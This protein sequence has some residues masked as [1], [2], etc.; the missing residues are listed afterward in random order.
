[1]ENNKKIEKNGVKLSFLAIDQAVIS[2]IQD[3][4]EKVQQG[5]DIVMWGSNNQYPEY[6]WN[7]YTDTTT[8]R[9]IVNGIADYV[10]GDGVHSNIAM[11][12]DEEAEDMVRNLAM[13]YALY[14]GYAIDCERSKA[15]KVVKTMPLDLKCIRSSEHNDFLYYSKKW[16]KGYRNDYVPYSVFNPQGLERSSIYLYKNSSKTVYPLSFL[17][18]DAALAAESERMIAEFHLNQIDNGFSSDFIINMNNGTPT[19]EEQEEIEDNF[20][21]KFCGH[22]NAGR[23]VI[24][25]NADKDHAVTIENIKSEDYG[26]KYQSLKEHCTKKL[27]QAYRALPILFGTPSEQS[28]FA[29]QNY[30]DAFKLFNR[31]MIEPIQKKIAN[32]FNLIYGV[33]QSLVFTPFSLNNNAKV[34]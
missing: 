17:A 3:A 30:E 21:E 5:K 16:G 18:T 1:M 14:G 29:V 9:T 8:L 32:S 11:L 34:D 13:D 20:N 25:F 24:A 15:G 10:V 26:Q 6:I 28:G 22:Q 12:G 4:Q 27:F 7:L 33:E 2:N 31:T 19:S 23:P